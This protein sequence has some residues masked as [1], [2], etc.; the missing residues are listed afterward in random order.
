LQKS[1]LLKAF[2][3]VLLPCA[4]AYN[5]TSVTA[6][7]FLLRE[8][9][10]MPHNKELHE[11]YASGNSISI[12]TSRTVKRKGNMFCIGMVRNEYNI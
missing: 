2:P 11:F 7:Y 8:G 5:D 1:N 6:Y 10:R 9:W 4:L 3:P 12:V